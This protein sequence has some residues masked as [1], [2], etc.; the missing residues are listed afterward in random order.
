M[1]RRA[2]DTGS[3]FLA[4]EEVVLKWNSWRNTSDESQM[5]TLL[6]KLLEHDDVPRLTRSKVVNIFLSES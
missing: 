5:G 1:G 2:E 3:W 6:P 4:E